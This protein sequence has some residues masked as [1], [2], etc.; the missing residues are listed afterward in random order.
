MIDASVYG[1]IGALVVLILVILF[2]ITF[3]K[4]KKPELCQRK[5]HASQNL[6]CNRCNIEVLTERQTPEGK[7][8]IIRSIIGAAIYNNNQIPI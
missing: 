2:V 8:E 5:R 4:W 3:I 6:D 7:F 1:S